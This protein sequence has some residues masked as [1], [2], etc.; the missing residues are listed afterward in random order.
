ML[1]AVGAGASTFTEIAT[2][3]G[4]PRGSAH[5]L[6]RALE[7]HGLVARYGE[8]GYRLGPRLLRLATEAMRGSPLRDLA[9]PEL[10]A[11]AAATAESTQLYVRSGD[12]RVCVDAV[13]SSQELRTIVPVGSALPLY[14]GSA[15]KVFLV[16]D[17]DRERFIRQATDP[18]RFRRDVDLAASRGWASS[19]DER[20][21]GVGSV[22]APILGAFGVLLAV[23]SI[24]G[25]STRV[26][27]SRARRH[28][29]AV[30]AAASA[31][32]RSLGLEGEP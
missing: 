11:L 3:T 19:T 5:R 27:R 31:I 16:H 25:P 23:V 12:A 22:S 7:D 13:E 18:E 32:E 15:A 26:G 21:R 6:L 1:D 29:E 8:L 14:A 17:D 20:Q 9:H 30:R 2:S 10:V 28:A 4:L 24:S